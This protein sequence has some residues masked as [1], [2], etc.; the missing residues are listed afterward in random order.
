MAEQ[1]DIWKNIKKV[2]TEA[3]FD[4]AFWVIAIPLAL[5]ATAI[6]SYVVAY[7]EISRVLMK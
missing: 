1:N 6:V 5:A 7:P 3:K 4:K 2:E